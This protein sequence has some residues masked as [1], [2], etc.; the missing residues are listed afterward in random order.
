MYS[1]R[2]GRS[3]SLWTNHVLSRDARLPRD[4]RLANSAGGKCGLFQVI[5]F[6]HFS[7]VCWSGDGR[8]QAS[9]PG[10]PSE[11]SERIRWDDCN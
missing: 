4:G 5:L 10:C 11:S 2:V 8:I 1:G 3:G 9:I 6:Q 7:A